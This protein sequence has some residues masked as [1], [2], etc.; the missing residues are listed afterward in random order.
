MPN[1]A[2]IIS[3]HNKNLFSKKQEPK[4]TIPSPCN[5]CNSVNCPLNG[6]CCEKTVIYKAL[7]TSGD[8]FK[9]YIGCTETDFDT[10][11]CNHTH[12][13]RYREKRNATELSNVFWN[14][15]VSGPEPVIKLSIVDQATAFQP[16]CRSYILCLTEKLA[17]L[18][19][20]KHTELNERSEFTAQCWQKTNTS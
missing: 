3:S 19:T 4:T 9:H 16:A 7:I 2:T 20:E 5:C 15:K 1:V 10:R 8:T 12:S 13:L 14:D 18:L 6:E 11:Y 17:I